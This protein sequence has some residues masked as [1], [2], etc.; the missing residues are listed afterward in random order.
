[1]R[2]PHRVPAPQRGHTGPIVVDRISASRTAASTQCEGKQSSSERDRAVS[3][4]ATDSNPPAAP[5]PTK[6]SDGFDS[7][8][9]GGSRSIIRG[10]KIKFAKTEEWLDEASDV[11]DPAREFIAVELAKVTQKWIDDN[12]AETRI[13]GPDEYFPDIEKLNAEAP[14]EEWREKFGRKVGPWQ[15]SVV[16]YLL[17]PKSMEGFTFVTSA[18]GGFR[19]IDELKGHVRRARMMQGANVYPIV[20]LADTHMRTQFGGRQRPRFKVVRFI[21]LGGAARP[22]LEPAKPEP[23]N[24]AIPY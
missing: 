20:T 3:D 15:N 12:P 16:L 18:I 13:L 7:V 2:R 19:A 5:A 8:D 6:V 4:T 1:M 10:A 21:T 23:V 14:P 24:D 11:I 9:D 22:L 17:D